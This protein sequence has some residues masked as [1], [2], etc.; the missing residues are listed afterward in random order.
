MNK[1]GNSRGQC[2]ATGTLQ[3]DAVKAQRLFPVDKNQNGRQQVNIRI[4][5]RTGWLALTSILLTD[6]DFD[7][8]A[9]CLVDRFFNGTK[10]QPKVIENDFFVPSSTN[11]CLLDNTVIV[12]LGGEKGGKEMMFKFGFSIMN[13]FLA[14]SPEAFDL[15]VTLDALDTYPKLQGE[16]STNKQGGRVR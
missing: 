14:N 2:L 5:Y 3:S 16:I 4:L 12:C 1:S 10:P 8:F 9:A 13:Q 6:M 7:A 15:C 11:T